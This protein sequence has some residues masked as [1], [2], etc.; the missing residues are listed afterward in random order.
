MQADSKPVLIEGGLSVDDRGTLAFVNGF[1]PFGTEVKRMYL[2]SNHRAGTVRAWHGHK[3]EGKYVTAVSGSALVCTVKVEDDWEQPFKPYHYAGGRFI[4]SANK[5]AV[6]AIPPG[7]ANGWMSL[8]DDAKLMWFSTATMEES[9]ADDYRWP[10]RYWNPW[11][12]KER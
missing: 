11:D 7:Y 5:P 9:A 1:S 6:L 2:T 10:A 4:L 3:L 12:V 8:T